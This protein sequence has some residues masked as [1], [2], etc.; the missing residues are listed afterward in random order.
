MLA[1]K[2][3]LS[4]REMKQ[5]TSHLPPCEDSMISTLTT[6]EGWELLQKYPHPCQ[7]E[8]PMIAKQL[9]K[10]YPAAL[11]ASL[12]TQWIL[13]EKS[14]I[15]LGDEAKNKLFTRE[16]LEQ[17]SRKNSIYTAGKNALLMPVST[18]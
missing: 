2:T 7:L 4:F 1:A 13:R 15:K 3:P 6:Q 18:P 9:R 5:L 8:A 11:V 10:R 17:A 14:Q 12:Q 16:G